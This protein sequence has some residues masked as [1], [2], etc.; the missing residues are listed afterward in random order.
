[1]MLC[2]IRVADL[3][4]AKKKK[5]WGAALRS[6]QGINPS[7]WV[8]VGSIVEKKGGLVMMICALHSMSSIKV[9]SEFTWHLFPCVLTLPWRRLLECGA[10]YIM[11]ALLGW[12]R[13]LDARR[14]NWSAWLSL[15]MFA[16]K[17][18]TSKNK[19]KTKYKFYI[20]CYINTYVL[21][22]KVDKKH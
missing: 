6:H 14:V 16:T 5:A 4:N 11:L 13:V 9:A 8:D 3:V 18:F 2:D 19:K 20:T 22:L 17:V 15:P 1:M 10:A 12:R 7:G 21:S